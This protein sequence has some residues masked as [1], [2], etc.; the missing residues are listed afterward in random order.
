MYVFLKKKIVSKSSVSSLEEVQK[1]ILFYTKII[2]PVIISNIFY[3][4]LFM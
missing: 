4:L 2:L 3:C 1:S